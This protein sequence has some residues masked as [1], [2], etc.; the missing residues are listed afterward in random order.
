MKSPRLV[1]G[2][3]YFVQQSA[4]SGA[5]IHFD[6]GEACTATDQLGQPRIG[7]CDIGAIE[8]QPLTPTTEL[9]ASPATT[10]PGG[11]ITGTWSGLTTPTPT[12]WLGLYA[13]GTADEAYLDW[14]Y[15]G[16]EQ[17]PTSEFASGACQFV[18]SSALAP[19]QYELRLFAENGFTVLATSN[20]FTVG[21]GGEATLTVSP[22]VVQPGQ[23]VAAVWSGITTPT[24]IDWVG[25]FAVGAGHEAYLDWKYVGCEQTPTS[26][27]ASGSCQ[28]V[29]GTLGPGDYEF[30]LFAQDGF[31]LLATSNTFIVDGVQ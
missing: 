26:E 14:K 16:C 2:A 3:L 30:R 4:K 12:D 5:R 10:T 29:L 11:L 9:S 15:V 8:F 1:P 19:G 28:F 25:L 31:T 6:A 24:P 23:D 7:Q 27:F 13:A 20:T 22:A 21:G 18:V 17:G